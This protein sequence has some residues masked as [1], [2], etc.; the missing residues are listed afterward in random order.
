[1]NIAARLTEALQSD[2]AIERLRAVAEEIGCPE[3]IAKFNQCDTPDDCFCRNAAER[4]AKIVS[5]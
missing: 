3:W 2:P 5:R 4:V 1:M